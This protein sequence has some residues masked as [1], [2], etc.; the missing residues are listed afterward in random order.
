MAESARKGNNPESAVLYFA[1]KVECRT[2][3]CPVSGRK[4]TVIDNSAGAFCFNGFGRGRS[5]NLKL[6][7]V[8]D[9]RSCPEL[10]TNYLVRVNAEGILLVAV[11]ALGGRAARAPFQPRLN[12]EKNRLRFVPAPQAG[13]MRSFVF[14]VRASLI[15]PGGKTLEACT[16]YLWTHCQAVAEES[17]AQPALEAPGRAS[18]APEPEAAPDHPYSQACAELGKSLDRTGI[19]PEP[20]AGDEQ[21]YRAE[22]DFRQEEKS[23]ALRPPEKLQ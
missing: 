5:L 21:I 8:G 20:E 16:A 14:E 4:F 12:R 11:P 9:F 17:G 6:K 10:C 1:D 22:A 2:R 23:G 15:G 13:E 3:R 19:L 18:S 7:P